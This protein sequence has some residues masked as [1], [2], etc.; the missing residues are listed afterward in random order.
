[1][2]V[3]T[4]A[5]NELD[6]QHALAYVLFN[7]GSFDVE[8]ITVNTTRGG[9][10]ISQQVAEARRVLALCTLQDKVPLK[11]G[12][13]GSFTQIRP[14]VGDPAFDGADAVNFIIERAH[15]AAD[16]RLVL[17]PIGKLTNVAL[18]LVKDP[19]IASKVRIVWLGSNY[20]DQGEYNQEN[21]LDA[22]RYVLSVDV[23]FEIATVRYG[24]GTGTDAVRVTR[25]RSA[26]GCPAKARAPRAG[27]RPSRRHLHDVRRLLG[28]PL[29]AHQARW[30]PAVTRAVRHGGRRHPEEPGLGAPRKIPAP[31]LVGENLRAE[32]EQSAA[33]HDLDALPPRCHPRGL[34]RD[35][36]TIRRWSRLERR[37]RGREEYWRRDDVRNLAI[38]FDG[39]RCV[40]AFDRRQAAGPADGS[41]TRPG[42]TS[43]DPTV[44]LADGAHLRH[45]RC[46]AQRGRGQ[47]EGDA[48][49]CKR[50]LKALAGHLALV[51][52]TDVGLA[53]IYQPSVKREQ[54]RPPRDGT[55]LNGN[56]NPGYCNMPPERS[57]PASV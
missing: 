25:R 31:A 43:V 21:D 4:D 32:H 22:V 10:D 27:D 53:K 51:N 14:H 40:A 54:V 38:R 29:R 52:P 36:W 20:P 30:H 45:G 57:P 7:G 16:S 55:T 9:G 28:E 6:D 1:M 34:L 17:L 33:R 8:G 35:A 42:R 39:R 46:R 23:P 13:N 50:G 49:E 56:Y 48:E 15:A 12:A 41:S 3:D 44:H 24:K 2:L 19:S 11:A 26:S 37:R 5:N 47:A 18:A